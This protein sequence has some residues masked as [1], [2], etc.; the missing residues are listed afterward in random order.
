ML[1]TFSHFFAQFFIIPTTPHNPHQKRGR[2]LTK[3]TYL[4]FPTIDRFLSYLFSIRW[5]ARDRGQRRWDIVVLEASCEGQGRSWKWADRDKQC[6]RFTSWFD[7]RDAGDA[8]TPAIMLKLALS[9]VGPREHRSESKFLQRMSLTNMFFCCFDCELEISLFFWISSD[10]SKQ[11]YCHWQFTS[12]GRRKKM[13][14][15][16]LSKARSNYEG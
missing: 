2:W 11:S 7:Y 9:S 14:F 13:V 1:E 10:F 6:T 4:Q 15:E 12:R 3:D 8:G 16:L 5:I